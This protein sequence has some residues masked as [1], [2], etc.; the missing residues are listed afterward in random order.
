MRISV[1]KLAIVYWRLFFR[2]GT[3]QWVTADSNKKNPLLLNSRLRLCGK[4]F[5]SYFSVLFRWPRPRRLDSASEKG[6]ARI[7]F[8]VKH[9]PSDFFLAPTT[10]PSL[11][12]TQ[13][14]QL[15]NSPAAWRPRYP[16]PAVVA[17]QFAHSV[18]RKV[19]GPGA[20]RGD[21]K[22]ARTIGALQLHLTDPTISPKRSTPV[23]GK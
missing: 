19:R 23:S 8:F 13:A 18:A 4:R 17:A 2:I 12:F 16:R 21:D 11:V 15:G 3:F 10:A 5:N 1:S 14:P 20:A 6:I 9:L 7:P 22:E